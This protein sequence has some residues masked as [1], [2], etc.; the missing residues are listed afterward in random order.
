VCVCVCEYISILNM[1]HAP[2]AARGERAYKDKLL[3]TTDKITISIFILFVSPASVRCSTSVL[4][5]LLSTTILF[6]FPI[7]RDAAHSCCTR[8]EPAYYA[9][10]LCTTKQITFFCLCLSCVRAMLR[11]PRAHVLGVLVTSLLPL[12]AYA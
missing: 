11:A 10:L 5:L 12:P 6:F 9:K 4:H 8:R 7:A 3:C 1:L 2:A